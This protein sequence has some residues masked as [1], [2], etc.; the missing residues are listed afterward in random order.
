MT[1]P[2]ALFGNSQHVDQCTTHIR[3]NIERLCLQGGRRTRPGGDVHRATLRTPSKLGVRKVKNA[4]FPNAHTGTGFWTVSNDA[5]GVG[6]E[7]RASP[8]REFSPANGVLPF[9]R[10][11]AMLKRN[12]RGTGFF[13]PFCHP[14]LLTPLCCACTKH[15][16]VTCS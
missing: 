7:L 6:S 15:A 8:S 14:L 12:S 1:T 5:S 9:R 10:E 16:S 2:Q 11:L 13:S 3:L 4:R